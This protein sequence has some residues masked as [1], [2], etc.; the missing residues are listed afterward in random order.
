MNSRAPLAAQHLPQPR[1]PGLVDDATPAE[2]WEGRTVAAWRAAWGLDTRGSDPSEHSDAQ[3]EGDISARQAARAPLLHIYEQAGSTNTIARRLA[4]EGAPA[5]S[6][7]IANEQTAGRG[8]GGKPW[9]ATAG[10]ALLFSIVLRPTSPLA[11]DNAPGAIPLRVGLATAQA[12]ERITGTRIQLKWPNDLLVEGKGK[13]AG[14]LCEGSLTSAAGGY[15]VA[16]IGLNV[17]QRSDEFEHVV[18]QPATS[19][20]L[21]TGHT[22]DRGALAGAI[23][24]AILACAPGLAAPLDHGELA[25]IAARD[26]LRGHR[27]TVDGVPAGTAHGIA[28]DG[29][30][31]IIDN[32]GK[33]GHLRNGT[34]RPLPLGYSNSNY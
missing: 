31:T 32:A 11:S 12:V 27:I 15:I 20:F 28:P 14:I 4:E 3:R 5:G 34:V 18:A 2:I 8:R 13:L 23:Q 1:T 9:H 25:E 22:Y 17:S 16:G 29:A 19:L 33:I 26:P 10:S 7:V 24:H 21:A 6:I 30:L